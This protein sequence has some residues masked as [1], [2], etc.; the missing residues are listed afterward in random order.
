MG[1]TCGLIGANFLGP[2]L[3]L[4]QDSLPL[5]ENRIRDKLD[6]LEQLYVNMRKE[7]ITKKSIQRNDVSRYLR[8]TQPN[9]NWAIDGTI[10]G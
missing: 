4:F 3:G 1:G 2:R 6:R 10:K 7:F 8:E 9:K 5:Q